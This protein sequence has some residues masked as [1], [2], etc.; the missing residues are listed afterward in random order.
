MW[1]RNLGIEVTLVN[2][3]W[4]VYL[5]SQVTLNY[6]LQRGGWIADYVDPHVFLEIWTTGNTNNNTGWS[7]AHYDRLFA[8]AIAAPDDATRYAIYQRME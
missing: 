7:N 5:D 2:Q 6:Q 1:R 4:K 3:E 8:Q